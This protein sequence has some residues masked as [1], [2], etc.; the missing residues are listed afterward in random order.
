MLCA[1]GRFAYPR[2]PTPQ[3]LAMLAIGRVGGAK[4]RHY[5]TIPANMINTL[6]TGYQ[7]WSTSQ[8][9]DSVE[10]IVPVRARNTVWSELSIDFFSTR[11]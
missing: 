6:W 8:T 5:H 7:F 4:M 2:Q 1:F 10:S 3:L 11:L 9:K